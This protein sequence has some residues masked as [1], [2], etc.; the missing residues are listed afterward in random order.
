MKKILY[1]L[2][3]SLCISLQ[4]CLYQED[5]YFDDSSANRATTDV[6]RCN[7]L[8]INAPNGWKLEYYAGK[9]YSMG[10]IT[11]LCKFDEKNVSMMS[12]IGS[13]K[14]KPGV[15]ITSLYK[16]VSEQ[17]TM[18]TFDT[19]NELLHCFSEPILSQNSNFQGDYEFAIMSA[20]ENEIILQ[21]KKHHNKMVMTPMQ[22]N[23]DWAT[24]IASLNKITN[25]AFL[26]T[27]ILKAGGEKVGEIERYSR[28]FSITTQTESQEAP[29][30]YTPEGFHF[31]Q[32]I[33]IGGKE[34]QNFKWNKTRMAFTC[35]DTGAEH[36]SIEGVYPEGYKKYEDYT[37]FYYFYYKTLKADAEGNF[38]FVDAMPFIV[39]LKQQVDQESYIMLGVDL[40]TD[41]IVNYEKSIGKLVLRPQYAGDIIGNG[42]YYGTY[43]L[44]NNE[45][46]ALPAHMGADFGHIASYVDADY[47][48][49]A[50][51]SADGILSFVEYGTFFSSIVG[52]SATSF[53]LTAYNS[54]KFSSSTYLGYLSWMDSIKLMPY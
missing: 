4:S 34:L 30:A 21:G 23:T 37:G 14:T 3:A 39:Q 54:E 40:E 27:Y 8:L 9:N 45:A 29:F 1:F 32:P 42:Q 48:L 33:T 22:A 51:S 26:N 41:I 2:L 43:I 16:V 13:R 20:S 10:G 17:S 19:F 6:E 28:V 12:E 35:T 18:L 15:E 24:Y 44:G 25:E 7:E 49:V 50:E 47:G 11:L 53:V 31:R 36:I 52:S 38:D 46:Y 5:S